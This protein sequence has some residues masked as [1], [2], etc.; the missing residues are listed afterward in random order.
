MRDLQI[1]RMID[2]IVATGS[3]RKAAVELNITPSA[4]NR[5]V[6]QFEY[7]FESEIFEL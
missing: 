3:V 4:L 1:F 6:R 5:R 7:E 2:T